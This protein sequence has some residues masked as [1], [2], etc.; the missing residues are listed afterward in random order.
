MQSSVTLEQAIINSLRSLPSDKQ[1]EVLDFVEFLR[2]RVSSQPAP[3]QP[4]LKQ[5]AALPLAQRHQ[6][7]EPFIAD[8]AADF[9]TDPTLTEFSILDTADLC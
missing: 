8:T 4:S 9:K 5:L 2:Q 7:L 1:Q 3:N 6:Q